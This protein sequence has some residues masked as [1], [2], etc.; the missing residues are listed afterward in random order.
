[1][2]IL[3]IPTMLKCILCG[4]DVKQKEVDVGNA[5]RIDE[6]TCVCPECLPKW[7]QIPD[8]EKE[9]LLSITIPESALRL[10]RSFLLVCLASSIDYLWL[11][12]N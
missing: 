1:M 4:F 3:A 11:F 10:I 5:K 2:S 6:Y 9:Q 8:K 7:K 12:T